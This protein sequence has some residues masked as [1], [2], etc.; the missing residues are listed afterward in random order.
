MWWIFHIWKNILEVL[1][2]YAPLM[3]IVV[4]P[5]EVPYVTKS[6]RKAIAT[7]SRLENKYYKNKT[8]ITVTDYIRK[9]GKS[10]AKICF[11]KLWKHSFLIW[12][13]EIV[14]LPNNCF[15]NDIKSL[16]INI[17]SEVRP[18]EETPKCRWSYWSY[19]NKILSIQV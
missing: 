13:W 14:A 2:K 4:H 7:R 11:G 1:Y 5:N 18:S 15:A 17:L 19:N 16:N 12:V 6:L 10:F 9:K 3:K 8:E